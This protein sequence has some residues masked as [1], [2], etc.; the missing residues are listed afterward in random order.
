MYASG[1]KKVVYLHS[2]AKYKGSLIDE[3]V[4]FL[5]KFGVAVEEYDE[6]RLIIPEN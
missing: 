6:A 3:G 1:V 2:Y 4:E 5:R